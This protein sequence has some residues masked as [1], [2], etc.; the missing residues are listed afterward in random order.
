MNSNMELIYTAEIREFVF[1]EQGAT[2]I[3]IER[4]M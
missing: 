1:Y 2:N 4:I 3:E